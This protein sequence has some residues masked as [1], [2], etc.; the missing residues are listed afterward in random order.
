MGEMSLRM[1][2]VGMD[3]QTGVLQLMHQPFLGG[4]G[5]DTTATRVA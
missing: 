4:P 5:K 1:R 2:V 3:I